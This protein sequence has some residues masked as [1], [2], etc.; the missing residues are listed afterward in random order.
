MRERAS[1]RTGRVVNL[2]RYFTV[3]E[4]ADGLVN[5]EAQ[6]GRCVRRAK[7]V[8]CSRNQDGRWKMVTMAEDVSKLSVKEVFERTNQ[9]EDSDTDIK[10]YYSK[11]QEF[12]QQN[13]REPTWE[14][15]NEMR[16]VCR[17]PDD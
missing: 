12:R 17:L 1:A 9:M 5:D 11:L 14:E 13:G 7:M 15:R 6:I 2:F 4:V 8:Y 10:A 16:D 3:S